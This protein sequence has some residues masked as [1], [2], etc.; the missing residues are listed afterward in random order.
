MELAGTSRDTLFTARKGRPDLVW[1]R[2]VMSRTCARRAAPP[3]VTQLDRSGPA[4]ACAWQAARGRKGDS[5][6]GITTEAAARHTEVKNWHRSGL[7]WW[8]SQGGAHPVSPTLNA[9]RTVGR[10]RHPR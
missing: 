6:F 3:L 5:V 7:S 2:F 9:R 1:Y 10:E 8:V 4:A